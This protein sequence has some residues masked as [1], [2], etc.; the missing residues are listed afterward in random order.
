[1][2]DITEGSTGGSLADFSDNGGQHKDSSGELIGDVEI[3]EP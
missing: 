2:D 1:M 3:N